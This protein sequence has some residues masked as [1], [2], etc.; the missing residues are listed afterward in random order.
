MRSAFVLKPGGIISII[1]H[2]YVASRER[3]GSM[4]KSGNQPG[5]K[6]ETFWTLVRHSHHWA[7]GPTAEEQEQVKL[8]APAGS[9]TQSL[10]QDWLHLH[11]R[12]S[13]TILQSWAPGSQLPWPA[14][15]PPL[16]SSDTQP[17]VPPTPSLAHAGPLPHEPMPAADGAEGQQ[18]DDPCHPLSV[19]E[20]TS[21]VSLRECCPYC[22]HAHLPDTTW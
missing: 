2:L 21:P 16:S 3:K 7:I 14:L 22:W 11:I 6:P 13:D 19:P 1:Y 9:C 20:W 15:F 18:V 4:Q 8:E 10:T 12:M 5:I 17:G